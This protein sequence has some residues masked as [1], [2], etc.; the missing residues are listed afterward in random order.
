MAENSKSI[1]TSGSIKGKIL[2]SNFK[3]NFIYDETSINFYNLYF[4]N[5]DLSFDSEGF[6][7][8]KPF[9]NINLQSE[10]KSINTKILK[11]L[12]IN[13]LI[14][15]KDL[16]RRLNSEIS[17]IFEKKR[18]SQNLIDKLLINTQLTYGRLKIKKELSI[19]NSKINCK[20]N[21][22]LSEE[23][24]VIYFDCLM[25]S[26]NKYKFMK[27][28]N[29][30]NLHKVKKNSLNLVAKGNLNIIKIRLTLIKLK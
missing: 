8:L 16:I 21:V 17:I 4:R 7:K 12:N 22:N 6:I 24:P 30:N 25:S 20:S 28:L 23:F 14:E 29:I 9:F 26:P 3:S 19:A 5:R 10:I 15:H 13:R 27:K 11:N 1:K 2:T 18:F